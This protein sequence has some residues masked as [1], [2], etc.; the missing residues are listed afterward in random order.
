MN[1]MLKSQEH[2]ATMHFNTDGELFFGNIHCING[3]V[4]FESPTGRELKSTFH[5][6]FTCN[7][8]FLI[9]QKIKKDEVNLRLIFCNAIAGLENSVIIRTAFVSELNSL[10]H[11]HRR[12]FL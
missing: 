12:N 3:L 9:W 6:E 5:E 8:Y 4:S 10:L 11:R 7:S 1:V 2:F